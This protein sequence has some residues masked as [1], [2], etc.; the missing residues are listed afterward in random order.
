MLEFGHR[1]WFKWILSLWC[2]FSQLMYWLVNIWY[3]KDISG[4]NGDNCLIVYQAHSFNIPDI[5]MA[6]ISRKSPIFYCTLDDMQ[7]I[8]DTRRL[9]Y[10]CR[11]WD[12]RF[13]RHFH[14]NAAFF[15]LFHLCLRRIKW[16]KFNMELKKKRKYNMSIQYILKSNVSTI[17]CYLRNIWHLLW[18]FRFG[19]LYER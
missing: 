15:L 10:N 8:L 4:N 11:N 12:V 2:I 13:M 6:I 9:K 17:C 3:S 5:S 7:C 18:K 14:F 19:L 1:N 16:K